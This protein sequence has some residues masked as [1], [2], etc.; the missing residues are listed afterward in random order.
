MGSVYIVRRQTKTRGERFHVRY[1]RAR[2]SPSILLGVFDTEARALLRREVALDEI[3]RNVE[4]TRAPKEALAA[5]S[6]RDAAVAWLATLTDLAPRTLKNYRRTVAT[7]PAWLERKDPLLVDHADIQRFV[8]ELA[9]RKFARATIEREIVAL[10]SVLDYAGASPNPA[11]DRRVR[12]P[13]KIRKAY[14]L[15]SR[16]DI[17]ELHAA[18]PDRIPLMILLEHTGLRVSEV[19]A[20]LPSDHDRPRNRILVRD[21]KTTAGRRW[22]ERLPG[23]PEFPDLPLTPSPLSFTAAIWHAHRRGACPLYSA[24]DWRHLHASR[25]LHEG[26]LS[27]AQIAA[28]L[29]HANAGVT[30]GVYSHVV[31]PD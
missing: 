6:V 31:P 13:R 12:L 19:A 11:S 7:L 1:Q 22:V 18:L 3:A 26:I 27:P 5:S 30:L 16:A 8:Q 2:R 24:H 15:P 4:P 17:L 20:L 14:R 28:R 29:G 25:L 9:A 21:S 10:R 23:A